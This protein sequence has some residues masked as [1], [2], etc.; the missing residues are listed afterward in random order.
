MVGGPRLGRGP[1]LDPGYPAP[2]AWL[3]VSFFVMVFFMEWGYY[4]SGVFM[5]TGIT[6]SELPWYQ[7][8]AMG[9]FG[10]TRAGL[11]KEENRPAEHMPFF[12]EA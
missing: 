12:E 1:R 4:F 5:A 2:V 3:I 10:L 7:L 11:Q 6:T 8:G 9:L